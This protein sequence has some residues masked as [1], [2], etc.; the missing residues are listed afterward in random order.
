MRPDV[1]DTLELP[2]PQQPG[3]WRASPPRPR[4]QPDISCVSFPLFFF[5]QLCDSFL[6]FIFLKSSITK[7][8]KNPPEQCQK[9][10]RRQFK[11]SCRPLALNASVC[12]PPGPCLFS[13]LKTRNFKSSRD[14]CQTIANFKSNICQPKGSIFFFATSMSS[15]P[16]APGPTL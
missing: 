6:Q 3:H 15:V 12:P 5:P 2:G 14:P 10:R 13:K 11:C 1:K 4:R 9:R 8:N 16:T 7:Q